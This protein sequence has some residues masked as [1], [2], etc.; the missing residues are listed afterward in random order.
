MYF[1]GPSSDGRFLLAKAINA[2]VCGIS[3]AKQNSYK[4][5]TDLNSKQFYFFLYYS[6]SQSSFTGELPS[7]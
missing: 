5:H 1:K 4:K 2:V 3:C 7:T 6:A